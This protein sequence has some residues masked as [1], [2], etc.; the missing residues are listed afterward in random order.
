VDP[1]K[2]GQF[3]RVE[4]ELPLPFDEATTTTLEFIS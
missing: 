3:P 1:A 2:L 4:A